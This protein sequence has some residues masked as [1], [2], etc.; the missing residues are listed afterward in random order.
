MTHT[1]LQEKIET[2][3]YKGL[4]EAYERQ[5]EDVNY[6]TMSFEERLYQLLDAQELFLKNKR[7]SMNHKLSKIKDKQAAL[8]AIA[9]NTDRHL[10]KAQIQSLTQLNF[11]TA[12]QNIIITG[13]TGTGKSYL[14]QAFANHAIHHAFKVYYVRMPSL[15]EEI[16]LSRIDG[17]YINLL[18]K[19]SRFQL[20]ILDDF[21][22]APMVDDDATNLFEIIEDRTS[23][24]STIITSQLP[25]S[26]WYNYLNNNTI[27]DAILDRI[28]H[29][30]H[31]IEFSGPSMRKLNALSQN[32]EY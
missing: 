24:N 29:S 25:V 5:S 3:G 1:Q 12:K 30:S 15:L 28:V 26:E 7:I 14:A 10:D 11:I 17:T 18:K 21:G 4:K 2:L 8:D 20:L 23:I 31:R 6:A 16:R 22:V 32:L 13:K 27:A 9:Y 19:Y